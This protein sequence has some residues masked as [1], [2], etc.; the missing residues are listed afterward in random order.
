MNSFWLGIFFFCM[1]TNYSSWLKLNSILFFDVL[2]CT[3]EQLLQAMTRVEHLQS[4]QQNRKSVC[5]LITTRITAR[6][7]LA[8]FVL[9]PMMKKI[10][11]MSKGKITVNNFWF[12]LSVRVFFF[13]LG[14]DS[15][16]QMFF[17]I[18]TL[19]QKGWQIQ[20]SSCPRGQCASYTS[21]YL[22][23]GGFQNGLK[24]LKKNLHF[25]PLKGSLMLPSPLLSVTRGLAACGLPTVLPQEPSL[26]PRLCI[27]LPPNQREILHAAKPWRRRIYDF[28]MHPTWY[29]TPGSRL[30]T[31]QLHL[32]LDYCCSA[33][34]PQAAP[35]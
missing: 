1:K 26:V 5:K 35:E 3:S 33:C 22:C 10:H 34:T 28:N 14:V 16:H 20:K 30:K 6:I 24:E 9:A 17:I 18:S 27:I 21:L 2:Q 11:S 32:L 12:I 13:S 15:L 7:R 19:L 25:S 8:Q 31:Q 4:L 29:P 23:S